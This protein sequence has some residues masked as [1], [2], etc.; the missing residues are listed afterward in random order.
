MHPNT[1]KIRMIKDLGYNIIKESVIL[2]LGCGK[3]QSVREMRKL[4]Y[5]AFGCDMNLDRQADRETMREDK[6]LRII[7]MKPYRLPFESDSVDFVFSHTVLEHVQNYD[8]TLAEIKRVLGKNGVGLHTFPSKYRL[9][10]AHTNVPFAS[11][12]KSYMWIYFWAIMGV[13]NERQVGM[14]AR[15]VADRNYA[16]LRDRTNYLTKKQLK[17][18]FRLYFSEVT[19]CESVF[20]KCSNRG[21]VFYSL[22]RIFAFIP[23]V[24]S[25]LRAR[26]LLTK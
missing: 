15:E 22:S 10:E 9:V 20:L 17:R 6:I 23:S 18:Q 7:N 1:Q 5:Q 24:Y 2:D 19:F 8:E 25:T 13:R 26:V 12:L 11:V 16:F 21:H 4:G 3:G 14:P